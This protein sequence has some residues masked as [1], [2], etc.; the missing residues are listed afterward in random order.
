MEIHYS[1]NTTT[2][3]P[4]PSIARRL[5]TWLSVLVALMCVA[6]AF[7]V[8][9]FYYYSTAP[10]AFPVGEMIT[11]EEGASVDAIVEQL[12]EAGYIRSSEAMYITLVFFNDPTAIKASTYRFNQ[13]LNTFALATRLVRGEFGVDLKRFVHY[14]GESVVK[15]ALRAE[16]ILDNFDTELFIELGTPLEG[17][18]F[19]DTYL[20]PETF[21]AEELIALMNENYESRVAPLRPAIEASNYT[22]YEVLIIASILEREANSRQTKRIVSGIIQERMNI[23]MPLQVDAVFEYI[24]DKPGTELT[25]ADLGVD[26]PYNT[27][28]NI[29]LPPTPIGNPGLEAIEAVLEPEASPY[30]FYLTGRDG[31]FYYATTYAG[32]QRNINAYLR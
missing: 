18:L 13:P 6:T 11:I 22:E 17:K 30:L 15:V 25:R 31:N 27:Y 8:A 5:L 20:L 4:K 7:L 14:E 23:G 19:P 26:S 32:H 10:D 29:G 12:K 16:E 9:T 2:V 21:T 28:E 1:E 3:V 24:L